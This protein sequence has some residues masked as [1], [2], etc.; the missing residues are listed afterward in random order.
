MITACCPAEKKQEKRGPRVQTYTETPPWAHKTSWGNYMNLVLAFPQV[1]SF[2]NPI[3]F[4]WMVAWSP[5]FV[6]VVYFAMA[7]TQRA[8]SRAQQIA[9][10]KRGQP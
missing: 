5:Q 9:L 7:L 3:C 10:V 6:I 8:L 2:F 1:T 4:S